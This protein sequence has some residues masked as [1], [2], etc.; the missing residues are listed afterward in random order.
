MALLE[1][2]LLVAATVA[3]S[4]VQQRMIRQQQEAASRQLEQARSRDVK[5]SG[6]GKSGRVMFG[7]SVSYAVPLYPGSVGSALP[8]VPKQNIVAG[9]LQQRA[10]RKNAVLLAQ[11]ALTPGELDGPPVDIWNPDDESYKRDSGLSSQSVWEFAPYET[12]SEM[13]TAFTGGVRNNVDFLES[14][15][16][17]TGSIGGTGSN[18][19]LATDVG[20]GLSFITAAF[21]KTKDELV[22]ERDL[23]FDYTP[24]PLVF[25]KLGIKRRILDV[26]GLTG[27]VAG[28]SN[29]IETLLAC[30]AQETDA[31]GLPPFGPGVPIA[32]IDLPLFGAAAEIARVK[33]QGPGL[34]IAGDA[35]V[36]NPQ[37]TYGARFNQL[38]YFA[39]GGYLSGLH[40]NP[41]DGTEEQAAAVNLDRHEFNGSVDTEAAPRA[42]LGDV[43]FAMPGV[44]IWPRLTGKWGVSAPDW[45]R[46]AAAQ[47]VAEL[48]DDDCVDLDALRIRKPGNDVRLNSA[49]LKHP[50]RS[51]AMA[52]TS[53]TFPRPAS[54]L[55]QQLI[56]EDN[57]RKLHRDFT[58]TGVSNVYHARSIL[59]TMVRESRQ[60]LIEGVKL[61]RE[62]SRLEPGDVVSFTSERHDE[63]GF[64]R[65]QTRRLHP[66]TLESEFDFEKSQPRHGARS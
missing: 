37:E 7:Q 49:T 3:T 52:E 5:L 25:H 31:S 29:A 20:A 24:S 60:K 4:V 41:H 47:S 62:W 17:K 42:M 36:F 35:N 12:A 13:A 11:W 18:E 6:S 55:G 66:M 32:R 63:A 16:L 44:M 58:G 26:N 30:L 48:T 53:T 54:T 50:D 19:R 8:L 46:T 14:G 22:G 28:G 27:N 39:G 38:G 57:G 33:V 34:E 45:R 15:K 51:L 65:I 2:A 56:T 10:T 40:A 59:W 9:A 64:F 1:I 43:L 23:I 21:L 61:R